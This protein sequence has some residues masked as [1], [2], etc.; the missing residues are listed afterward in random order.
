MKGKTDL[1]TSNNLNR[2]SHKKIFSKARISRAKAG[3]FY[4]KLYCPFSKEK[5]SQ[6][7]RFVNPLV[8][9]DVEDDDIFKPERH[10]S[11][12][13]NTFLK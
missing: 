12:V 10:F 11:D 3:R 4:I 6:V 9:S 2:K 5:S 1:E 8:D 13:L 7:F